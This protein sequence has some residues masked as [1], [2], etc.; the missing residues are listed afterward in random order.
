MGRV[1]LSLEARRR[2]I[3]LRQHGAV[4]MEPVGRVSEAAG[5]VAARAAFAAPALSKLAARHPADR[6]RWRR[7]LLGPQVHP[8][9][10]V[11]KAARGVLASTAFAALALP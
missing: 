10:R 8:V 2:G 1:G 9:G 6:R 4:E 11:G 5:R 3:L 7:R